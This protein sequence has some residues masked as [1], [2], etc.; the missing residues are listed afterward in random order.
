MPAYLSSPHPHPTR[1]HLRLPD[2]SEGFGL[3]YTSGTTGTPKAARHTHQTFWNWNQALIHSLAWTSATRL[4]NPYPLFHMGGTA[5]TLAALEAGGTAILASPFNPDTFCRSIVRFSPTDTILVPTMLH[6][7][8]QQPAELSR[9]LGHIPQITLTSAPVFSQPFREARSRWPTARWHI[10]YSATEALFSIWRSQDPYRPGCV[11]RPAW[12][13]TLRIG[14]PRQPEMPP[15][16]VGTIWA[17]GASVFAGYYRAPHQFHAFDHGWFTCGDL[18]YRDE[19]GLVYL[20][21]RQADVIISGGEKIYSVEVED[22]LARHPAVREVAVVGVPDAYWG[23]Q[24][25]AVVVPRDPALNA[26]DLLAWARHSLADYQLPKS[27][28]IVTALPKSATGKILKRQ[29]REQVSQASDTANSPG[30]SP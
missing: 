7:L 10:L 28:S 27:F 21:D 23:E 20:V 11:G 15:G 3:L 8:L 25:H 22:V 2:P 29:L 14:H 24:V 16:A 26:P 5:F 12:H 1:L 17:R 4:L 9:A 18:G 13:M 30:R 19:Q 6:A